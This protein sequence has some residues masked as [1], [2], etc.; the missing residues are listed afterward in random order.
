MRFQPFIGSQLRPVGQS[1]RAGQ[2]EQRADH[3]SGEYP[4][5]HDTLRPHWSTFR[6]SHSRDCIMAAR[7]GSVPLPTPDS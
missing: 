6:D 1:I 4:E 2:Q 5:L 3:D 7:A